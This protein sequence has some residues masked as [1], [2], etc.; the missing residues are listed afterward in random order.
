MPDRPETML[1]ARVHRFGGPDVIQLETVPLPQVRSGEVLVRVAAAG[2]GPWDGWIR[3]GKSALPQPLPLTLGSDLAGSIVAIGPDVHGFAIGDPVFGVTNTRFTDAYA[4]YAIAQAGMIA[5]M[6]TTLDPIAAASVPVIAVTAQQALFDQA[7]LANGQTVLIHGAA[8]N[9]G[10][11]AVQLAH[12]AGME[13][14]A[15]AAADDLDE[16]RALGADRV[17]DYRTHR[18]ED[19]VSAVDAVVDLVGGDLQL[20]SIGVL[21]PGGA[22]ISAV[23][24]P[25]AEAAR[26]RDVR[27]TFFLVDVT[28]SALTAIG[29]AIDRGALQVRV[30]AT[31]P[32]RDVRIAHEMLDGLH[33]RPSGKIVLTL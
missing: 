26:Q 6:P 23:S 19:Q 8:G 29:A 1:A 2:V 17:I 15:T 20:R 3:A 22:L 11:Y 10:R 12:R 18:F 32:I 4:G 7:G 33:P 9:V 5:A 13:V 31:L 24:Q 25:D 14:V 16:V 27:A 21:K 30:G 28:T